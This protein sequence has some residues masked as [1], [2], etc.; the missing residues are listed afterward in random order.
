M[1]PLFSK[2]KLVKTDLGSALSSSRLNAVLRIK[3]RGTSITA[4]NV[5][6][7][8]KVVF[9]WYNQKDRIIY[10]RER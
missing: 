2:L 5:K 1:Q 10:Q 8:D 4:F 9:Y 6:Y 7:P 3:L